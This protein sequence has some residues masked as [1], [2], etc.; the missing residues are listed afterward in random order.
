MSIA[1]TARMHDKIRAAGHFSISMLAEHQLAVS[2][3]FAGKPTP[4]QQPAFERLG[5]L[6][7]VRGAVLQLAAALEHAYPCGD[8]TLF[9]GRALALQGPADAPPPLLFHGGRYSQLHGAPGSDGR[10]PDGFSTSHEQLW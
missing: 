5:G 3:H 8:H 7:V 9:V 1:H 10:V 2:N 6:P 4:G